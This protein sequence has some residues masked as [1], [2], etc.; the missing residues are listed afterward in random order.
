VTAIAMTIRR[1]F[2]ENCRQFQFDQ[3]ALVRGCTLDSFGAM[4]AGSGKASAT[5]T[6]FRFGTP[7]KGRC[8]ASSHKCGGGFSTSVDMTTTSTDGFMSS[9]RSE[10]HHRVEVW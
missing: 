10:D 6:G 7:A 2:F 8:E 5:G 9:F 1:F 4:A 3:A